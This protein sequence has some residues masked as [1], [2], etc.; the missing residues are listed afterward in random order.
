MRARTV[1]FSSDTEDETASINGHQQSHILGNSVES[2]TALNL[3]GSRSQPSLRRQNNNNSKTNRDLTAIDARLT[4][5]QDRVQQTLAGGSSVFYAPRSHPK[6]A[7]TSNGNISRHQQSQQIPQQQQHSPP[8]QPHS[9]SQSQ[10]K[11]RHQDRKKQQHKQPRQQP[12][13]RIGSQLVHPL[14]TIDSSL[15]KD[16]AVQKPI[17][18]VPPT[19]Q[20]FADERLQNFAV[21]Y[22]REVNNFASVALHAEVR[23]KQLDLM[24][25]VPNKL[26]LAVTLDVLRRL[27]SVSGRYEDILRRVHAALLPHCYL[28]S[29]TGN[30]SSMV[31]ATTTATPSSPSPSSPSSPTVPTV[32]SSST[33]NNNPERLVDYLQ[34]KPIFSHVESVD[35]DNKQLH[36]QMEKLRSDRLS[37][38]SMLSDGQ[39]EH[40]VWDALHCH[41][42]FSSVHVRSAIDRDRTKALKSIWTHYRDEKNPRVTAKHLREL[43]HNARFAAKLNVDTWDPVASQNY[44]N[45]VVKGLFNIHGSDVKEPEEDTATETFELDETMYA[46]L[47]DSKNTQICSELVIKLQDNVD[48]DKVVITVTNENGKQSQDTRKKALETFLLGATEDDVNMLRTMVLTYDYQNGVEWKLVTENSEQEEKT[49]AQTAAELSKAQADEQAILIK[50]AIDEDRKKMAAEEQARI[51]QKAIFAFK[52]NVTGKIAQRLQNNAKK[53]KLKKMMTKFRTTA[54][55][56]V[57]G[58]M[59]GN[60]KFEEKEHDQ[61]IQCTGDDIDKEIAALMKRLGQEERNRQQKQWASVLNDELS[62]ASEYKGKK[63]MVIDHKALPPAFGSQITSFRMAYK[64]IKRFKTKSVPALVRLAFEVYAKHA[65]IYKRKKGTKKKRI[66]DKIFSMTLY[67][68]FL[69]RYGL[70]EIADA[71]MVGLA[72]NLVENRHKDPRLDAFAKFC[73]GEMNEHVATGYTIGITLLAETSNI[74][75]LAFAKLRPGGE[76]KRLSIT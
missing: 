18:A 13:R 63:K 17:V 70:P 16:F 7:Q 41:E 68:H 5:L 66:A 26:A 75:Q 61:E 46:W 60:L 25:D 23:L 35:R 73:F 45:D 71:N 28:N 65:I 47:L 64:D 10:S 53:K 48:E 33:N 49:A 38:I 15:G 4:K 37:S 3:H 69:E 21:Q 57:R 31:T 19:T 34:E 2:L 72:S 43:L 8:Q 74:E 6:R 27:G 51:A 59:A 1:S 67:A 55:M 32:P 30:T 40:L 42:P 56:C 54:L 62:R 76:M 52:T 12:G 11:H 39:K 29:P 22:D 58:P 9:L 20:M 36:K 50:Q 14:I 44:R 24:G